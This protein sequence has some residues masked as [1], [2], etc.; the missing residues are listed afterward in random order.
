MK[1]WL[2]ASAAIEL[3]DQDANSYFTIGRVHLARLRIRP[4]QSMR[5]NMRWSS[6]PASR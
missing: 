5:F 1:P 6:I 3:D 4:W 2:R